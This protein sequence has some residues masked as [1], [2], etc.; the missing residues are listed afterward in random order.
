MVHI[1]LK[2]ANNHIIFIFD[3]VIMGLMKAQLALVGALCGS[4]VWEKEAAAVA[5]Q[6]LCAALPGAGTTTEGCTKQTMVRIHVLLT[7]AATVYLSL[8]IPETNPSPC[9]TLNHESL[10]RS[11]APS[12]ALRRR[13]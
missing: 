7:V 2:K 3:F 8:D 12:T 4:T 1:S 9:H 6:R 11:F 10:S 13:S 5:L